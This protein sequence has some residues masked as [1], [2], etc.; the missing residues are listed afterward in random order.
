MDLALPGSGLLLI[1]ML[2]TLLTCV[3][4]KKPVVKQYLTC[5]HPAPDMLDMKRQTLQ[6]ID[7]GGYD[8]IVLP[9]GTTTRVFTKQV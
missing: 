9:D 4:P 3:V 8:I 1:A 6:H 2:L 7:N 5:L